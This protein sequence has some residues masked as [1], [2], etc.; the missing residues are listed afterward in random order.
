MAAACAFVVASGVGP[1]CA[2]VGD[3][4]GRPIVS[5]RLALRGRETVDPALSRVVET[6]VGRPLSMVE[7]RETITH[8]F[9]LA[10]FEDV[11][12]EASL[13]GGGVALQYD[14]VPVRP[15]T[16]MV[17]TGKLEAP[18]VT[19][20]VL[21]R[22]VVERGGPSPSVG[23]APELVD[24]IKDRLRQRGYL[25][26][27]VTSRADVAPSSDR[28]TLVFTVDPGAQTV[29]GTVTVVGFDDPAAVRLSSELDLTAGKPY[30]P[31]ALNTRID[32][33]IQNQK[34]RGYYET[35]VTPAVQLADS[36]RLAN[37]TLTVNRG[38]LVRVVFAGDPLPA[39]RRSELV[40]IEREGSAD[41][42][43]L[44]DSTARIEEFLHQQG[45][46]DAAAPH[47]S[48]QSGGELLITFDVK[49][50]RQYRASRV[51]ISGNAS[52][53]LSEFSAGLRLRD[54]MPFSESGLDADVAAIENQYRLAGF[55]GA[56]ADTAVEPEPSA[57]AAGE[58]PVIV[59]IVVREGVRT[60]VGAVRFSG[61]ES[62]PAE[63]LRMLVGVGPDRPFVLAQL[64]ADRDAIE[65]HYLNLGFAN[66]AVDLKRELNADG[67]RAD[68]E[69]TVREGPRVVVDHVLIAGNTRTKAETIE[70]ELLLHPGDPLGRDAIYE[71]QRNLAELGLFRRV[72]I[73]ELRHGVEARRDLVVTVSEAPATSIGYG[74]GVEGRLRVF[75]SPEGG[76]A[77]ERLEFAPRASFEISRRN[78]FGKNRSLTGFASA[79]LHPEG[80][81]PPSEVDQAL[82]TRYGL[83]EYRVLG[84]FRE[85]RVF[86]TPADAS[87]TVLA[88]QQI[89]SSFS[90]NR[91]SATAEF[92]RRLSGPL[93]FVGNYQIQRTRVFDENVS[94]EDQS[95]ID[96]AFTQ[97]LLS[98]FSG[99]LVRDTRK[100]DQVDP[101]AGVYLSANGQ[102]A[103]RAIGSEVGF[104]KTFLRAQT[105]RLLPGKRGVVFAAN[106]SLG[107]AMGFLQYAPDGR[108]IVDEN[109]SPIRDLPQSER[110][111]AGGDTTVRGFALD[112][113]GVRHTPPQP[114]DTID[115]DGFPLGGNAEII[116]NAELR[117]PLQR[118]LGVV[119]FLDAGNVFAR[120]SVIDFGEF[121]SAL[122]FGV[123]YKSPVGPLRVDLGF[124]VP[125]RSYDQH[126]AVWYV[127]FG[128]AF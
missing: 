39:D 103:A 54:G 57:A 99:S 40:P 63:Q 128:Q 20:E 8:L 49:K 56:K 77:D 82:N 115:P 109:G 21:R 110:F 62:V 2:A 118:N 51:D 95:L 7:V 119:G 124:K 32:R 79:S 122:G 100:P 114:N 23:R 15:V 120:P 17:F 126:R 34:K 107:L 42:D 84:T 18:G 91:R 27:V 48:E 14:L 125:K 31:E 22:V 16:K 69:F 26:P 38:P 65:L 106:G 71:S 102:L 1:V 19:E 111:Y 59:R 104:I 36:D 37:I 96:R 41:E 123:R 78:L 108:P 105:F 58:V 81:V 76:Q 10:R 60:L 74:G 13:E 25:H 46:R 72:S 73:T 55:V 5:V 28:T 66:V 64:A 97:V 24:V 52:I 35:R 11:R 112:G 50:G 53:P 47:K 67:S 93:S 70:R 92:T 94:Q 61:N 45:Y 33:Y 85:P 68:V 89:R 6:R 3:Y 30:E 83:V 121:R 75:P 98:S 43:L 127:T 44:E 4:V 86:D 117:V 87:V 113:L 12:V 116:L 9:S 101:T 29:V 90:Y 80:S 88:E